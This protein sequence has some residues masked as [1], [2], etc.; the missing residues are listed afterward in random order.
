MLAI[1][2][3]F[4]PLLVRAAGQ[5]GISIAFVVMNRYGRLRRWFWE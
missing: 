5:P 4:G 3:L 2:R 1:A